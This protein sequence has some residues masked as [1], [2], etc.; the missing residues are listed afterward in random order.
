[1]LFIETSRGIQGSPV[2]ITIQS[3]SY[4][5]NLRQRLAAWRQINLRRERERKDD[6]PGVW[7]GG[8]ISI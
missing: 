4:Q 6:T 1:M 2:L 3:G 7:G 8:D 5:F